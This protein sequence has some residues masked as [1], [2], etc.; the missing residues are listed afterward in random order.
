MEIKAS[1]R[2]SMDFT[3]HAMGCINSDQTNAE[4]LVHQHVIT[5]A[6]SVYQLYANM[7]WEA[8]KIQTS[9]KIYLIWNIFKEI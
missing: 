7:W 4:K 3:L 5:G 2:S 8:V 1:S 6:Y 9:F